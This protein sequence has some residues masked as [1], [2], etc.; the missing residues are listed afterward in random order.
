MTTQPDT[1]DLHPF[2]DKWGHESAHARLNERMTSSLEELTEFYKAILPRL[3]EIINFLN[4]FPVD[5]IPEQHRPL[6]Y[7]ALAACEVEDA[8][9][10]WKT[11][12]LKSSDDLRTW[13]VK[14]SYYDYS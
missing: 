13:R 11:P 2:I 5:D 1:S 7:T 4:Q 3:K 14:E 10:V 9:N 8:I 6:A 12:V